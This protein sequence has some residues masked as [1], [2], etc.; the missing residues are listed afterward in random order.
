[1]SRHERE[2]HKTRTYSAANPDDLP[3]GVCPYCGSSTPGEQVADP[4]DDFVARRTAALVGE[5]RELEGWVDRQ[6]TD[7]LARLA[8]RS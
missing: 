3:G 4:I 6:V 2:P 1:M 8:A 7:R 5:R